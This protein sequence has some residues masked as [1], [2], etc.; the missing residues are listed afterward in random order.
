M[1]LAGAGALARGA[2]TRSQGAA[3]AAARQACAQQSAL[4]QPRGFGTGRRL[5][6]LLHSQQ[7][8]VDAVSSQLSALEARLIALTNSFVLSP[9]GQVRVPTCVLVL[10]GH[11]GTRG[12]DGVR[13]L[14]S[15]AGNTR[16]RCR[17]RSGCADVAA[18]ARDCRFALATAAH[19]T[20]L[21]SLTP[22]HHHPYH[23][24]TVLGALLPVGLL[25]A[26][27]P[28]RL[29]GSAYELPA[30]L[31]YE[32]HAAEVRAAAEAGRFTPVA[33]RI[34]AQQAAQ[35]ALL[36]GL[37]ANAR[38]AISLA[39][40]R[41]ADE[42]AIMLRGLYL[43]ALFAPL[44]LSSPLVF[45]GADLGARLRPAWLTLL[46]GTL[47]RAGPAFIK[48]GQWGST[49][50]D[51]F[52]RDICAA[53]ESLQSAAPAHAP[54]LSVARV[55][56]A[57]CR[58][59]RELFVAWE[60]VPLASGSIA[61][62]HRARLSPAAAASCGVAPGTLVAVKVRHPGVEV[63]MA[64]DFVLMSRAAAAAGRLP[65]LASLRLD[66]S[67]RQFGGPLQEQL[68]LAVEAQHLSKF[69]RNFRSWRNVKFPV[70]CGWLGAAAMPPAAASLAPP[71]C[72]PC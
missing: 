27:F 61:Q 19:A 11:V 53:L 22:T 59:L 31:L 36:W 23:T 20:S 40:A 30:R 2:F 28:N 9:A 37:L 47:E 6:Q 42:L 12:V 43:A 72:C 57:F 46:R 4:A 5:Q 38:G 48:W 39:L 65:G 67:V 49:R 25:A 18:A 68:N 45:Y 69:A 21:C 51:L 50:P 3:A 58:P 15:S 63:V 62:I 1:G 44:L 32:G 54:E 34:K 8:H 10:G 16:H 71:G 64:R 41:L 60:A 14:T 17:C 56:A 66:E 29:R 70:S 35:Q 33:A 24:Q 55:E 26:L 52:P 7:H 13:F